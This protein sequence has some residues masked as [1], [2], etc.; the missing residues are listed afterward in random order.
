VKFNISAKNKIWSKL[1]VNKKENKLVVNKLVHLLVYEKGPFKDTAGST[2][3]NDRENKS[4]LGL[5]FNFK[6][7]CF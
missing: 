4:C 2:K 1:K 6:L 3:A 5:V 7:G